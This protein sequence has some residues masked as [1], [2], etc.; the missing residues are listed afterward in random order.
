MTKLPLVS[1]LGRYELLEELGRGSFGTVYCARDTVL[2]RQVALKIL[3]PALLADP[4]FVVRFENDARAAA[5]LSHPHIVTV[6][7]LG[8]QDGRT[9]IAM[10]L[11]PAGA[12]AERIRIEGRLPFAEAVRVVA[13]VAEALDYA[14][15]RGFVHRDVK[16]TNI[17]FS[18][19]GEA[20]LTDFG[21]VKAV[22]GSVVA[23]STSGGVVGTPAYIAPEV[24][25]G[26]EAG[27]GADV[28]ALGCVLYE[29]LTGGPIFQG[30]TPPAVMLAHFK[31]LRFPSAWP[32]GVPEEVQ[33]V[34]ECSLAQD[35]AR[36]YPSAGA[37]AAALEAVAA[38]AADPL[39]RPYRALGAAVTAEDW[40]L[41]QRLVQEISAQDR[42]YR[43]VEL[44]A[45]KVSD[46][47]ERAAKERAAGWR[48]QA[49]AAEQE[50]QWEAG[51]SAAQR[52]LSD[53]PTD[54]EAA[55][56]VSRLTERA[57]LATED[58]AQATPEDRKENRVSEAPKGVR[59][60][61]RRSTSKT[62]KALERDRVPLQGRTWLALSSLGLAG[63]MLGLALG[64][65]VYWIVW[66]VEFTD[67]HTYDLAPEEKAAYVQLV[68]DATKVDRDYTRASRLLADWS[69]EEKQQAFADAAKAYQDSGLRDKARSVEDLGMIL[70]VA[71]ELPPTRPE[72]TGLAGFLQRSLVVLVPLTLL[73]LAL[74]GIGIGL[75]LARGGIGVRRHE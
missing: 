9:Y 26:G 61:A 65:V 29:M 54:A 10:Q 40:P 2:G 14:H 68:S 16:P 25:E 20:V 31:P 44:L 12:L 69:A 34:L 62:D 57:R 18:E 30:E 75:R 59:R 66:P 22:E 19:R 1:R 8:Q 4:G 47:M 49:L 50:G 48:G 27:P 13:Q 46:G 11:L 42:A 73:S 32:E 6:H 70:Q 21:L 51:L 38:E 67:A 58:T 43:D 53:A 63:V 33:G 7:D 15:A 60:Q 41:A 55:A 45:R 39:A 36:R 64:M 17:L 37:L 28:Y 56:L 74:V 72:P 35:P 24:W 71:G 5:S 52:W 3:H 23:R